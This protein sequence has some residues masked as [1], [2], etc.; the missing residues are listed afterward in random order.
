MAVPSYQELMLPLLTVLSEHGPLKT[1]EC[2]DLIAQRLGFTDAEKIEMLPRGGQ[3]L[4]VN[5][6]A[7][8][9][10][11]MIHAGLV[12][13]PSRGTYQITEEGRALLAT[14]PSTI[15]NKVLQR[16][17]SFVERMKRQAPATNSEEKNAVEDRPP[18]E[19]IESAFAQ[20]VVDLLFATDSP[21]TETPR[22]PL[23]LCATDNRHLLNSS[24]N[25]CQLRL[26]KKKQYSRGQPIQNPCV[27]D[28][29][30]LLGNRFSTSSSYEVK[31]IQTFPK[32]RERKPA[33]ERTGCPLAQ[34]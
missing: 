27:A 24:R 21:P 30:H 11:Y 26:V 9:A 19:R 12:A 2:A 14:K 1:A 34:F 33:W 8:A 32:G 3:R 13:R 25:R 15:N 28:E 29:A 17:P 6:T 23:K 16:Y 18:D 4:I 10:W 5:R 20:L 22:L 31:Q 7:W